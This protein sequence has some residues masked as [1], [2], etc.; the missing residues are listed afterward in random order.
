MTKISLEAPRTTIEGHAEID[1]DAYAPIEVP[2]LSRKPDIV[3][4][5][6]GRQLF[7]D[8]H[9]IERRT[10]V[11]NFHRAEIH[12]GNPIMTPQ[13]PL[14]IGPDNTPMAS[15]FSGGILYDGASKLYRLWYHAGWFHAGALAVSSDGVNWERREYDVV[16]GTNCVLPP[17]RN[18]PGQKDLWRDSIAVF[19]DPDETDP[20]R[21]FKMYHTERTVDFE[22][23]GVVLASPDGIHWSKIGDAGP[24]GDRSTMFYDPFRRQ[25]VFSI[26]AYSRIGRKRVRKFLTRRTLSVDPA[27]TPEEPVYWL[28]ADE[29]DLPDPQ[30]GDQPQ[31]YNFDAA[32][33][34]SLMLG[35]FTI[36]RGPHNEVCAKTGEPKITEI[37]LGFSRDGYHFDRPD[38]SAFI[39]ATRKPGDWA[40]GFLHT[41]ANL[42]AVVGD[43]L[44][45]YYTGCRGEP[46]N[47]NPEQNLNGMYAWCSTG[48]ATLRRDGFA[49]LD[50]RVNEAEVLTRPLEFTG[51]RLFVN[52]DAASGQVAAELIDASGQVV[53]GF[54][55]SSCRPISAD[56]TKQR[57]IW[58]TSDRLPANFGRGGR[59]RF[60]FRNARLFSFWITRH[61]GGASYG[62]TG[63]GGPGFVNGRDVGES[64]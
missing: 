12:D 26:R 54:E 24:L 17:M 61:P 31:L 51:D 55:L 57:I 62:Y 39:E 3:N 35:A 25:W 42:C 13:T 52:A 38:R 36:H 64:T 33:Y 1:P 47:L 58:Q 23:R 59:I 34:E 9:L 28:R 50:A 10:A 7:V 37:S 53:P 56:S 14:E 48:L 6:V 4:I 49:S 16:P 43:K 32:P 18:V 20:A 8:D 27:W 22:A 44:Y 2:Y 46:N 19:I 5:D 30:I 29:R 45:F 63:G 21:R 60:V 11:R 41:T 15:P 40:R